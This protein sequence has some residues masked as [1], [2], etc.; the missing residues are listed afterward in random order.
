MSVFDAI[1]ELMN[2]IERTFLAPKRPKLAIPI[3]VVKVKRS[4][5]KA[6]PK[7]ESK[8]DAFTEEEK[9]AIKAIVKEMDDAEQSVILPAQSGSFHESPVYGVFHDVD[10]VD[11][12]ALDI[13]GN[14]VYM[15]YEDAKKLY[16][17]L[18]PKLKKWKNAHKVSQDE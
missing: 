8:K 6:E 13:N 1:D 3:V 11:A 9:E 16:V 4:E 15:D 7:A 17:S 14:K 5:P 2:D 12:L 10:Y 18:G